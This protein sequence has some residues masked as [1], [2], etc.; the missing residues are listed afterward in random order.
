MRDM[1]RSNLSKFLLSQAE[2][3]DAVTHDF[4]LVL[5]PKRACR[6]SSRCH[7]LDHH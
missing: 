6:F 3:F 5:E 1:G 4:V 2:G 7:C